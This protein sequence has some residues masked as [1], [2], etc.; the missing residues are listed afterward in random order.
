M[1]TKMIKIE[2]E[3]MRKIENMIPKY[4]NGFNVSIFTKEVN[5]P[6]KFMVQN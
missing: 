3:R 4:S 6:L 1:S 5:V 2:N